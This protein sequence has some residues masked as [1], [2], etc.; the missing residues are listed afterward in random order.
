MNR[1]D[2]IGLDGDLVTPAGFCECEL[3][4]GFRAPPGYEL[5][6]ERRYA[7][8]RTF[9]C[10]NVVVSNRTKTNVNGVER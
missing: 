4:A 1:P 3:G 6:V 9:R 10:N 5:A 7:V 8:P 2:K